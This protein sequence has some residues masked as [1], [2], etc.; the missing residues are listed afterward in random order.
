M[1][2]VFV[3]LL[4][5]AAAS[6]S[7]ASA[8]AASASSL[9]KP[10]LVWVFLDDWG[11]NNVGF[12]ARTQ[13][14]A[15]EVQTPVLDALAAEGV[16]LDEAYVFKFCSPSRS[17]FHTGRNPLQINVLN[18]DLA[19]AN[20]SDPVSGYAGL[21]LNVTAL[22]ALLAAQGYF[23]VAAGKWHIGLAT[24]THTPQGRGYNRSLVYLDG[25]NDYWTQQ[26]GDWC[27]APT[28]DLW[29]DGR[30]ALG[31]NN[32]LK[33]SQSNQAAGCVYEDDLFTDFAVAR[34][35]EHNASAAPLFL[36]FAPHSVHL[37]LEVPQAQLAKFAFVNDSAP[38]Q[39]Y[40]AM[41]NNVDAMVG[42]VVSALKARGMWEDSVL[43]VSAD[44]GGPIFGQAAG[45]AL[46]DGSAGANN[47]PL[48]GGKHSNWQGGVRANCVVAGGRLPPA[49]RNASLPG[50]VGIEDWTRT[51]GGLAGVTDFTDHAAAAAG[52]PPVAGVDQ[53]PYISGANATPPRTEIWLGADSPVGGG[54][55]GAA[56][57]QG[58]IR[59]DGFKLLRD[60]VDMDIW[61]G[62]FYPNA[63]TAARPWNNT[64][65]DCGQLPAPT[66]LFNIFDDPTEHNNVAAERGDVVAEMAARIAELQAGVFSPFRGNPDPRAC[67][68]TKQLWHGFVG[69]FIG[70]GPL[71]ETA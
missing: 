71:N 47:F 61:T 36:Y 1:A 70:V 21:P 45:C 19:A 48:R 49:M 23:T 67:K 41:V 10:H 60:V 27:A 15:A 38:R 55:P 18:S 65:R 35:A 7:A 63:T 28:V 42:R 17:A 24:P 64:G 37:P 68:A 53:W 69:P 16:Q 58:L 9:T 11:H 34:I 54:V 4:A 50:L 5:A 12:H 59:A 40:A 46:C 39:H 57:V 6:A 3:A 25:A 8:S 56:F 20:A 2:F 22:P 62:P 51:L 43:V 14:N 26:T 30:P 52:L 44:N 31:M 32:S 33:C 29:Q 66:C 13:A